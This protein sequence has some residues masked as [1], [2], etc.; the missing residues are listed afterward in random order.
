LNRKTSGNSQ[1]NQLFER[2]KTKANKEGKWVREI[3]KYKMWIN[4][5]SC[6]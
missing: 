3:S 1:I 4:K 5:F 6:K 2:E